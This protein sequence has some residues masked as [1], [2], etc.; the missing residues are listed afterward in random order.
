MPSFATITV[1]NEFK[2]LFDGA[3]TDL[4]KLLK[5]RPRSIP[6]CDL[7]AETRELVRVS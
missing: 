5:S 1:G 4:E 2:L 6:L 7:I 3:D